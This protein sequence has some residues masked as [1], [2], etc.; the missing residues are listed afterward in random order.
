MKSRVI[1]PWLYLAALGGSQ[2]G[3]LIVIA[4]LALTFAPFAVWAYSAHAAAVMTA[5][6]LFVLLVVALV[7]TRPRSV[8]EFL[9]QFY[10]RKPPGGVAVFALLVGMALGGVWYVLPW[11][12]GQSGLSGAF[13]GADAVGRGLLFFCWLGLPVIEELVV[14]GFVYRV[15]REVYGVVVGVLVVVAVTVITHWTPMMSSPW[16]FAVLALLNVVLCVFLEKTRS[17]WN[18]IVCHMAYNGMCVLTW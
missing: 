13:N 2:L 18:C 10:L 9:D 11:V 17:L 4:A 8:S 16:I 3:L 12:Q 6:S 5:A 14:R 7:L 1:K 15:F